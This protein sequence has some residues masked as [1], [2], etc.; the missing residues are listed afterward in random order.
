M[1][2]LLLASAFSASSA[3]AHAQTVTHLTRFDHT[4]GAVPPAKQPVLIEADIKNALGTKLDASAAEQA[5]AVTTKAITARQAEQGKQNFDDDTSGQRVTIPGANRSAPLSAALSE[6]G[7]VPDRFKLSAD[8]TDD[9]PSIQRAV[10]QACGGVTRNIRFLHRHYAIQSPVSQ[11][12]FANWHGQGWATQPLGSL[13][14]APGTWLEIGPA[15]INNATAPVTFNGNGATGSV[16]EDFG[17]TEPG[18]TPPPLPVM[19][20]HGHVTG[21]S[22]ATWNPAAYAE[23]FLSNFAPDMVYRHILFDGVNAGIASVG[24]GRTSMYDIR[25]QT[26]SYLINVQ[27]NQ[28]VSRI[29]DVHY[30]PF[31]S[32][33]DPV[34]QW[35]QANAHGIYSLR[36]DTPFWDRLFFFG[37]H[38]A[39]YFGHESAGNTTGGTIGSISCDS[40]VYCLWDALDPASGQISMQIGNVRSYG[41]KWDTTYNAAITQMPGSTVFQFDG[42]AVMQIGNVENFGS[43]HTSFKF[44]NGASPSNITVQSVKVFLDQMNPNTDL[45]DFVP[46]GS[47]VLASLLNLATPPI[48]AGTGSGF[49]LT[50]TGTN[51][52]GSGYLQTPSF[53]QVH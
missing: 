30:W 1:K 14:T 18:M 9:A 41:Q 32:V 31:W 47:G 17:V 46:S 12:C 26:F 52:T 35:Q 20:T 53:V 48:L 24:S 38:D 16:V 23:V 27:Q 42:S 4:T 39:I 11:S 50:N 45:A 7:I 43:D 22:P 51:G 15:F 8:G 36:N 19:D 10:N 37:I 40:T 3:L 21:W 29:V 28:D 5:N 25:G 49:T 44:N 33:A 13:A 34:I 6:L 2:R